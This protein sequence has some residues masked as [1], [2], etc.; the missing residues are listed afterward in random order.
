MWWRAIKSLAKAFELSN[1]AEILV[2][3][4][5]ASP[6]ARKASTTPAAS[7]ASGP[8]TVNWMAFAFAKATNAG[9]STAPIATFWHFGSTAV[10]GF[11]GATKTCDTFA[12]C[13]NFHARACSRPP[14]PITNRFIIY[15]FDWVWITVGIPN[16]VP[17]R[18]PRVGGDP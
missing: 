12:D 10:A 4:K 11:P 5:I 2:G 9:T 6:S 13:A 15:P 7:G 3:P 17:F 18:H 8:T 14:L 1:C 16:K